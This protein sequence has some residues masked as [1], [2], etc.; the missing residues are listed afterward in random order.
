MYKAETIDGK[1]NVLIDERKNLASSN[2]LFS[3]SMGIEKSLTENFIADKHNGIVSK[4]VRNEYSKIVKELLEYGGINGV[5]SFERVV[6]TGGYT[7][8]QLDLINYVFEGNN[9]LF[10]IFQ[11]EKE[12]NQGIKLEKLVKVAIKNLKL[13]D[14]NLDLSE[15]GF[16]SG[17]DI[18]LSVKDKKLNIELKLNKKARMGSFTIKRNGDTFSYTKGAEGIETKLKPL[19]DAIQQKLNGDDYKK[20]WKQYTLEGVKI[21]KK[22]IEE[23]KTDVETY[24]NEDT[25]QLI[26]PKEVFDKLKENGL[27]KALTISLKDINGNPISQELIELLYNNKDIYDINIGGTGMF[28]LGESDSKK[29]YPRLKANITV[30]I[31][32]SRASIL[33]NT[34][35][36]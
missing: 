13:K 36:L 11:N 8:D 15:G 34:T 30:D 29:P 3:K 25:G 27:Q 33:D 18:V 10:G 20:A 28:S 16:S 9:W 24:V 22:L 32:T 14:V 35:N 21:G 4:K 6:K 19:H 12:Q 7:A 23:G 1:K 5:D 26:G 17:V 2:V 31:V